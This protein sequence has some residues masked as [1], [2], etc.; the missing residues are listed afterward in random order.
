MLVI[1]MKF[2]FYKNKDIYKLEI[3]IVYFFE[4][5]DFKIEK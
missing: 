2:N 1:Y 5:F 3:K 4:L